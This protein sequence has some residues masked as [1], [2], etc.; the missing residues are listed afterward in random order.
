MLLRG[1]GRNYPNLSEPRLFSPHRDPPS[2]PIFIHMDRERITKSGLLEQYVLGLTNRQESQLVEEAIQQDPQ[3]K[4]DYNRL[5][6][7][8]EGYVAARSVVAPPDGERR[9]RTAQAY[10]DLDHEMITQMTERNHTL[11]VWRYTLG[12]V[13]IAL[14]A[15]CGYLFRLSETNRMDAVSERAEHQQDNNHYELKQRTLEQQL[16]NWE[17]VRSQHEVTALGT[18]TLH[19]IPVSNLSLLDLSSF[20]ELAAGEAYF[21]FVDGE[22][23]TSSLV[24]SAERQK[25]LH[26]IPLPTDAQVIK[27]YRWREAQQA[28]APLPTEDLLAT[29]HLP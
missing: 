23:K 15:L 22:E 29:V 9:L 24:V 1:G 2:G 21:V 28:A 12:A 16:P 5:R 3:I 8:M 18:V 26:A 6:G 10:E 25:D 20:G 11:N 7:E 13:C 17:D 14:V 27:I 19:R 4:E